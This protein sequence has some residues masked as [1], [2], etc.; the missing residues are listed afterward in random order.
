MF[1]IFI[2]LLGG[3]YARMYLVKAMKTQYVGSLLIR[4]HVQPVRRLIDYARAG[5]GQT[6][7]GV[8]GVTR[9]GEA[10]LE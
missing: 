2:S 5:S 1:D 7:C 4:V 8:S 6:K 10:V 9:C 3:L